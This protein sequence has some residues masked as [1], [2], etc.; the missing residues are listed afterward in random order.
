[1]LHVNFDPFPILTTQRLI[2]RQ[3]NLGDANEIYFLRSD[4]EMLK[5]V[6][7]PK[8][9]SI[10]EAIEWI[11]MIN[12]FIKNNEGVTW[13]IT[14][15]DNPLLIGNI[16]FWKLEKEHY[17]T[18]V[19]YVLHPDHHKKGIMDEALKAVL[20]YGFYTLKFHSIEANIDPANAASKRLLERNGFI[21]EAYYK[22]NYFF[23]G[24]FI[25]SAIYSLLTPVK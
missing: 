3:I 12:N 25:D 1:M 9:K 7:R 10:Q 8:A 20:H 14:L 4:E 17:R 11:E 22:E 2:L 24:K 13:A 16:G 18:Q 23:E 15:K 5:Y 19:G 6:G 21:R